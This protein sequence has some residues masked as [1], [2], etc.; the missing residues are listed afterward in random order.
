[1][2]KPQRVTQ[3][4]MDQYD[5]V[6]HEYSRRVQW[7]TDTVLYREKHPMLWKRVVGNYQNWEID[8]SKLVPP[9]AESPYGEPE[10]LFYSEDL[11][12]WF[13]RRKE[14]M[15]Y[16]FRNCD[17]DELHLVSRGEM[18]YETD[19]GNITVGE[20]QFLLI[21]KGVTYRVLFQSPQDTLR[22]IYESGPEIYVVPT[23][24]VDHLY[25]KGRPPVKPDKLQRP[26]LHGQT[27]GEGEFEVRVKYH[28][29]FSDFLGETSTIVYDHHP[30]DVEMIDGEQPVF[31][32]GVGDIEKLG[33]PPVAFIGAA[34]LDNKSNR[35]WTLHLAGGGSGNAPV[36][37]N[38]DGDEL[39][40]MSSGPM[41][42]NF[43]FTPQGVDHG[44]GRGYTKKERN[45]PSVPYDIGD[46]I[47]A[48]T[49]KPL[50]G[51]PVAQ[52]FARPYMA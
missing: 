20:R 21:P 42:G 17:A 32:F 22:V 10:K 46:V 34:Y 24:M 37:R 50:K 43:L 2:S 3:K 41:T 6:K 16:F 18:T 51:T 33:S 15:P 49:G 44:D 4:R 13:S 45:R 12:V 27:E 9:D 26:E 40:Y 8:T 1:M 14:S 5:L 35:A 19:F 11:T 47:S 38:P 29:A 36:H 30:F 48:Y 23:E 7:G 25:G 31:K 39:R 52:R 28:G